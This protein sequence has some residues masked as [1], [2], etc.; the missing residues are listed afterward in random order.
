MAAAL[1]L[2]LLALCLCAAWA[3]A[4]PLLLGWRR[5]TAAL[6]RLARFNPLAL[7]VPVLLGV[8]LATGAVWPAHSFS[9]AWIGCH[10]SPGGGAVHLCLAHPSGALP[11]LPAAMFLLVWFGWRPVKVARDLVLRLRAARTL[12]LAPGWEPDRDHD[13]LLGNL[14]EANAFTAGLLRPS[15]LVDRGWWSGL[16]NTERTIVAAHERAHARCGDPLTHTVAKFLAGLY[17]ARLTVPLLDDWLDLAEHRADQ[18]AA[19]ATGDALRVADLLMSQARMDDAPSLVPAFAGGSLER[20]VRS[21]LAT[22]SGPLHLGSDLRAGPA[23][24]LAALMVVGLFGYQIHSALEW[25][26]RLHP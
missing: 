4:W 7:A 11:L 24:A 10:C 19:S 18:A 12:R 25:L 2:V 3:T 22:G 15:V 1:A 20:R 16:S 6:P 8:V 9:L 17:P 5:L 21:L 23:L 26:V 14:G 13:V